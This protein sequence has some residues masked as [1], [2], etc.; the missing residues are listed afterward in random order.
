MSGES[1]AVEFLPPEEVAG[2]SVMIRVDI[3]DPM[4][5]SYT[6]YMR[7]LVIVLG[8]EGPGSCTDG[9]GFIGG[10]GCGSS[11]GGSEGSGGS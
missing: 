4:D 3:T 8:T 9:G 5:R 7:E 11:S 2:E 1:F 10:A 6:H